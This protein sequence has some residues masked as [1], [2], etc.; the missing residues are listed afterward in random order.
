MSENNGV[1]APE[2]AR[3]PFSF[4]LAGV[5]LVI[6]GIV[7][8]FNPFAAQMSATMFLAWLMIFAGVMGLIASFSFDRGGSRVIGI[9]LGAL[10]IFAGFFALANPLAASVTL[11]V[12]VI[13]WLTARGIME[14]VMAVTTPLHRWWMVGMGLLDLLLAFLLY[15]AGPSGAMAVIGIYVAISVLFWGIWN[16]VVSWQV[17]QVG[18]AV[19]E[20]FSR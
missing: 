4:T 14:L 8:L 20:E 6:A 9:I 3:V 17:R 19:A 13:A 2:A 11:T 1:R 15:R 10:T 7:G 16:L 5:L 18:D 12:I